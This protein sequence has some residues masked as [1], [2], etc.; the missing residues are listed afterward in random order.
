VFSRFFIHRPIFA[1]VVSI[2]LVLAGGITLFNLPVA[3]YPEIEPPTVNVSTAYPGASAKV[4]AD[5][6]AAPIEQEINGVEGMLYMSSVS[7][8]D[9]TYG[10]TVTFETGTDLD[11]AAVLV[12]NRVASAMASLPE[13][14]KRI[15][16]VTKKKSP[17]FA[18]ALNLISA[19]DRYDDIFLSNYATL[20]IRDEISRLAGAGDV[21]VMGAGDYSMRL[22]LDPQRLK[23]RRL[24]AGDVA[25][26]LQEQNVQVAA[27]V[28]GQPPAPAGQAFQY[29]VTA[30]GRLSEV[31]QFENIIV[32]TGESGGLTRV[33]DVGRVE[34]GAQTYDAV[35]LLNGKPSALVFVYQLP[36]ANLLNLSERVIAKMEELKQGFPQGLD[37]VV[38]YDSAWAVQASVE[39]IVET[40]F[41]AALLVVFTVFVFLQDW[42]ATLIPA[43]TIPV[44]LIGTFLVMSLLGFSINTLTLFGLVLAIGIV[45]DDAIVVVENVSRNL[46]ESGLP[47]REATV[48]AMGEV[49]GPVVATT[50]VLLAVFVP[51]AFMGGMVGILYKQFALTIATATLFSSINALTLSPA[52]CALLLRPAPGRR[53]WLFRAFNRLLGGA[54][55]GYLRVVGLAVRRRAFTVLVFLGIGGAVYWGM[56]STPTGFVPM[57]DQGYFMT[58][59]QLPD[60]ASLE[61]SEKVMAQVDAVLG[62]T[63]G[64]ANY[65]SIVGYSILEGYAVSNV[66]SNVVVL[67]PWARREGDP[68][69]SLGA[70]LGGVNRRLS[71]IQE[72][73]LVAFPVPPLPGLGVAGG[74]DMMVEDR[75]GLGLDVLQQ[76]ARE[77][78]RRGNAQ[79]ELTNLYTSIRTG[80]PQLFVDVDR[81][82]ALSMGVPLAGVFNTMQSLLGSAYV[83]DF[84]KFGRTYQVRIQADSRFRA[85]PGDIARLQ[86]RN[87]NGDMV[88]LGSVAAVREV[89]GPQTITRYNMFPAASVKGNSAP[90]YSS[91]QALR[92]M[93]QT[94]R[95]TLPTGMGFDWT[96]ESYQ[97]TTSGGMGGLIFGLAVVF[98][99][100]VLAAQYESWRIPVPVILSVPLALSGAFGALLLVG[101]DNNVYTQIGL[102]LL[103]GLATK[104]AILIVEFA[105]ERCDEGMGAV[106]AAIE[107]SRLRFRPIL[108]TAF[109]FI[110]G[111]LPLVFA[112]GAGAAARFALGLAVLGGMLAATVLGVVFVPALFTVFQRLGA[113]RR[114]R[115]TPPA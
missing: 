2:V 103:V 112:S 38:T 85:Q 61:R 22:W 90:G 47:P 97:E 30:L 98:V 39:E 34:L 56:V 67:E 55:A 113:R 93:A 64:V 105:K 53:A 100:L 104:N 102:V 65:M 11:M 74:F 5:T 42:R 15:G 12:Q 96:G 66:G 62:Q 88:P 13:E 115:E 76:T 7:A 110:L 94:A 68:R 40:L 114:G 33:K 70:I 3:Q 82:K 23:A 29:T 41:I 18:V 4:V 79:D 83:N 20:H 108:M 106:E 80:V 37:Y 57:E 46:D 87:A 109:S 32:K 24:T 19:N 101:Q 35:S 44:S 25:R 60:G 17:S 36:G 75:G 49:T 58:N 92:V 107:A 54:T 84:N 89:F 28:I 99:Y 69:K 48:K 52:L 78:V 14:V 9:G 81:T 43:V 63:P 111:V 6:V 72:A 8:S 16:V 95:Q 77:V 51:T 59:M 86:V 45:V 27:G 71:E 50:L 73:H 1:A 21:Q 10:L 31:E 26:A 91:G